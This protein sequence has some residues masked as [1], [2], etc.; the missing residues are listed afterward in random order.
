MDFRPEFL[1]I[2]ARRRAV[3]RT[4]VTD[5]LPPNRAIVWEVGCGHGHFLVRYASAHPEKFCVGIDLR[6][7]RLERSGRKRDRA[8][9]S[10]C[11]FL[12]A[13]AREFFHALP[14]GTTFEEI[15]VLFPDPWPKARHNKNRLLKPEFFEAVANRAAAGAKFYFR[16][17][18]ASYFNE[19]VESL[20][21]I[22]TW[23]IDPDAP[24]PLEPETV[25][26]ERATSHQSLTAVRTSHPA[27]PTEIV[28][29]GLPPQG[30]PRSPA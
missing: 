11:H 4:Q 17:D 20:N 26:Q 19:V 1:D 27:T 25:F 12:R 14:A 18:D 9:A 21:K 28:A 30:A 10:N 8:Q 3:L 22:R 24:W 5:L 13:E 15:W 7:E 29:P 16:T 2:I 23:K 6:L